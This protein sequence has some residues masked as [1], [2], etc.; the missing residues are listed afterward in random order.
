MNLKHLFI[1]HLLLTLSLFRPGDVR[2]CTNLQELGLTF[3]LA[4][5]RDPPTPGQELLYKSEVFPSVEQNPK[6]NGREEKGDDRIP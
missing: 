1:T 6:S 2:T 3:R 5:R 4:L